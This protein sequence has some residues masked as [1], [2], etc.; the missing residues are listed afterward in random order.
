MKNKV[1]N[2]GLVIFFFIVSACTNEPD[3]EEGQNQIEKAVVINSK[4]Q[5]SKDLIVSIPSENQNAS[6]NTVIKERPV[7]PRVLSVREILLSAGRYQI[8]VQAKE[9]ELYYAGTKSKV[10]VGT[11]PNFS[12]YTMYKILHSFDS[13]TQPIYLVR[14]DGDKEI[15]IKVANWFVAD[16]WPGWLKWEGAPPRQLTLTAKNKEGLLKSIED[17]NNISENYN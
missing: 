1:L 5:E 11:I 14:K 17:N 6:G 15:L 8:H 4:N 2:V 16:S 10:D 13:M 3:K 7:V 12:E 9:N